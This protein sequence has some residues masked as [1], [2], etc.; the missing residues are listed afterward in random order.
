MNLDRGIAS[1]ARVLVDDQRQETPEHEG[2]S[3]YRSLCESLPILLRT[4]GLTRT[5]TFLHAKKQTDKSGQSNKQGALLDHL[6]QQLRAMGVYSDR[7][8]RTLDLP[9]L[10]TSRDLSTPQYRHISSLAFR[11][12]YWH[13]RLAQALLRPR[14]TG[15]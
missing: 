1:L 3:D 7:G 2:E 8:E 4:A 9:R 10:A 12:A 5:V 11:A 14:E 15:K 13:K 6:Q